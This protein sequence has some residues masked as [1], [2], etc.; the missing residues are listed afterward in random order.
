[1]MPNSAPARGGRRRGKFPRDQRV[2]EEAR[3]PRSNLGSSGPEQQGNSCA[4]ASA[5]PPPPVAC[6]YMCVCARRV[7]ER[8]VCCGTGTRARRQRHVDSQRSCGGGDS[9]RQGGGKG[10]EF[11]RGCVVPVGAG[12]QQDGGAALGLLG[13]PMSG[14]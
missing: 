14:S 2:G 13:F 8:G 10:S 1:M 5:P 12:R 3:A 9:M 7:P 4:C 11:S 6:V